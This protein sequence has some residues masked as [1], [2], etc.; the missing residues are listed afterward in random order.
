MA[1]SK[2]GEKPKGEN[3]PKGRKGKCPKEWKKHKEEE[4]QRTTR[5][6]RRREHNGRRGKSKNGGTRKNPRG[7]QPNG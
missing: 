2:K 1:F 7:E 5:T 6:K 3:I 4:S